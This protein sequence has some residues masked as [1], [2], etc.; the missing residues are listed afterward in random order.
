MVYV[1]DI[2]DSLVFSDLN[3]I[4]LYHHHHHHHHLFELDVHN[5]IN[6]EVAGFWQDISPIYRKK[7]MRE[8]K[9]D[10]IY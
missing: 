9:H 6:G 3:L 10:D 4:H 8:K 1:V 5:P 7:N 2:F